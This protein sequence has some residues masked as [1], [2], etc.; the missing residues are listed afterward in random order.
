MGSGESSAQ[1]L[2]QSEFFGVLADELC[3]A[4]ENP[5][6]TCSWLGRPL[7]RGKAVPGTGNGIRHN[8]VTILLKRGD[9]L[10]AAGKVDWQQRRLRIDGQWFAGDMPGDHLGYVQSSLRNQLIEAGHFSFLIRWSVHARV[11]ES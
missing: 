4:P 5:L 2:K 9:L 11:N 8:T 3:G 6:A 7:P 10:A 1:A